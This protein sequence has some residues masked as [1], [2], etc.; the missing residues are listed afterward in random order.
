MKYVKDYNT[1]RANYVDVQEIIQKYDDRCAKF[2]N[3]LLK[4]KHI[5][6]KNCIRAKSNNYH[7]D[8]ISEYSGVVTFIT[9]INSNG[10]II[11]RIDNDSKFDLIINRSEVYYYDGYLDFDEAE[12][13]LNVDKYNL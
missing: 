9:V 5:T 1:S 12:I 10:F 13:L 2:L 11:A 3:F 7:D 4:G 6:F 8:N